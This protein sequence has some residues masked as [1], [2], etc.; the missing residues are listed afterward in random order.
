MRILLRFGQS[1]ILLLSKLRFLN[2]GN[3]LGHFEMIVPFQVNVIVFRLFIGLLNY[4][5]C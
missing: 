2:S 5:F 1:N 4:L 3:Q